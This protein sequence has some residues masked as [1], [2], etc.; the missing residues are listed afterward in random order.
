MTL[1]YAPLVLTPATAPDAA[2]PLLLGI[3][4][5]D[6]GLA[7]RCGLGNIDPQHAVGAGPRAPAAIEAALD[8]PLPP[9]GARLATL[10]ADLDALGAMAVLN[11]RAGGWQ[12]GGPARGRI[13]RIAAV[14]RFDRGPWPGRRLLPATEAE[15]LDDWP[16]ADLA[17]LSAC[18]FDAA[19]PLADRVA[20]A[21][22]WIAAG[23]VPEAWRAAAGRRQAGLIASL[24][25]GRTR[26]ALGAGGRCA[27]VLSDQPG[28]LALG[29]RLAPVVLA[30]NPVFRF[31]DGADGMKY[32]IARWAEG[33]ADLAPARARLAALEPGWG[34]QAGII[35]S[36]QFAPSRLG[37]ERVAAVVCA[38]L[39][40]GDG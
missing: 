25:E 24:A 26:A 39:R 22:D 11:L 1:T 33:D 10:R 40:G 19:A 31:P 2:D 28:A 17:V 35:G 36:P 21:A 23:R 37:L 16:G 9:A 13:A 34:G 3:E 4:V 12:A 14:D 6:P 18:V 30:A 27:L 5:T 32:T 38:A 7:A 15:L 20:A 8:H 29:Y